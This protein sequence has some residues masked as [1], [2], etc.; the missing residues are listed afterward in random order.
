MNEIKTLVDAERVLTEHGYKP[1]LN[2][3]SVS[4]PVGGEENP[5]PCLILMDETYLTVVC[6]IDTVGNML[7]RIAPEDREDFLLA[8]WDLNSQM[9]SYA[10]TIMSDIDDPAAGEDKNKWPVALI[11]SVPTGD[12]SEG[13]LLEQ[14]R[15]L[16]A[17]LLTVKSLFTVSVV[18]SL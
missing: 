9:N 2:E 8:G 3:G 14:M 17:A 7:S 6:E 4:V 12:L 11:N 13:E 18:E 16:Q 5:F 15:A 1:T 10:L